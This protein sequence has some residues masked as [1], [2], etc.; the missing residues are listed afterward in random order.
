M[1]SAGCAVICAARYLPPQSQKASVRR[2]TT[3]R[4]GIGPEKY[5]E[6]TAAMIALLKYGSGMPFYRMEKLEQ[7]LGIPLPA[8]TQW[9]IVEEAAEVIQGARNELITPDH[10][11]RQGTAEF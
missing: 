1:N 7:L 5:D 10:H 8:S 2:N 3:K 11:P 4:L 9:K 6:T